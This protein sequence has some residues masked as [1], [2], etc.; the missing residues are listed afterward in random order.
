[1]EYRRL[2]SSPG[3]IVGLPEVVLD[4]IAVHPE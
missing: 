2:V 3:N 4:R 1:V